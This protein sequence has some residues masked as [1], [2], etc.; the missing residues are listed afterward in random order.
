MPQ[1]L[2][3]ISR[4]SPGN[5]TPE[6]LESML[7]GQHQLVDQLE[8]AVLDGIQTGAGHHW[9][10]VGPRGAGKTH[11]LAILFNRIDRNE[12]IRD[13]FALAYMKE[14]ERG[15]ATSLDW[16]VR[17]LRAFAR[18]RERPNVQ[19]EE[20]VLEEELNRLQQLPLDQARQEA[21]RLLLRFV[22]DRRLLL[23]VENLGEIF[24]EIKGMG[25]EGQQIFR[26]LIQQ[27]PFWT[28]MAS[29][30]A[31]FGDIQAREAPFYGFFKIRHLE[32]FSFEQALELLEKLAAA[33]G[34]E[35]LGAFFKSEVGRGRIRAVHEITGGNPRLLVIFYQFVDSESIEGLA[36]PFLEMVDNL[37]PFY[38]EQMQ[39]LPALQQKIVEFLCER[40]S[41]VTVKGIAHACFVSSQSAAAQLRR[42]AERRFVQ[43]TRVGRESFYELREPLLRICFEVKENM[44][45]PIRLFIDF[46]GKF[47][48]VEELKRRYRSTHL[49]LSLHQERGT[50]LEEAKTRNELAYEAIAYYQKAVESDPSQ[51]FPH[52]NIALSLL[53]IGDLNAGIKQL[54]QAIGA[55]RNQDWSEDV[56]LCINEINVY[57]L[58]HASMDQLSNLFKQQKQIFEEGE[59]AGRLSESVI[60]ALTELLE[61]HRDILLERLGQLREG[62]VAELA[63]EEQFSVVCRLFDTGVRFLEKNDI[64]VLLELPLE[65]RRRLEELL[66]RNKVE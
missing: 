14:E 66:E 29:T 45:Y 1:R 22:G 4:F 33:E 61:Q 58:K 27:H 34:R 43:S 7:V 38:Q 64:R 9:L 46:L 25:R 39:P 18:R 40:R 20:L 6:L 24:S 44:G 15:V 32:M 30:Q 62:V 47:Y 12:D 52:F 48:S 56:V 41:P 8:R 35:E 17:I 3:S 65:E 21:E 60:G 31:L 5:C 11:L 23:I 28:I 37:T 13:R 51:C 59:F 55:C 54:E 42:L 63:E 53:Q 19:E 2:E 50:A 26:D 16:L 57:L 49:L 36:K 10:L